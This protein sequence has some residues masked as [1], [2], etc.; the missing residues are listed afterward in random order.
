M[1]ALEEYEFRKVK[2]ENE[3]L[4]DQLMHEFKVFEKENSELEEKNRLLLYELN[5]KVDLIRSLK[6]DIEMLKEER[7]TAHH[8]WASEIMKGMHLEDLERL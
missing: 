5:Q 3:H 6:M 7:K 8:F 4:H 1:N 2:Q